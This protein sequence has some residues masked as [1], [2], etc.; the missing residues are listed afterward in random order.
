MLREVSAA[1]RDFLTLY[2]VIMTN[3]VDNLTKAYLIHS[4]PY[5]ETSLLLN[6]FTKE[7]GFIKAIAKGVRSS[8]K[9][10]K[11]GLLQPFMPL[12]INWRGNSE[13]VYLN[14]I[15]LSSRPLNIH[16]EQL[17]IG[18]YI[19]EILYYLLSRHIG[20]TMEELFNKY[21][22]LL[23]FIDKKDNLN[24]ESK[25]REF[26]LDLLDELGYGILF[27]NIQDDLNYSYNLETGFYINNND[28]IKNIKNYFSGKFVQKLK[29]RD[30]SEPDTLKQAKI[31]L[32][33]IIKHY[34]GDKELH[35]RKLYFTE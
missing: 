1:N 10:N 2:N 30:F 35:S 17:A 18:F 15:E 4:Q 13:L 14:N 11:R 19:N 5:R 23:L 29:C 22:N 28:N 31:L 12:L 8:T 33:S 27:D 34:I 32:R 9:N 24:L 20:L 26:E 6:F 3:R 16:N 21:N 25:L 7:H